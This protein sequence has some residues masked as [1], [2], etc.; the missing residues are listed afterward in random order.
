MKNR[1]PPIICCLPA[2][3][4]GGVHPVSRARQPLHAELALRGFTP[5]GCQ[6]GSSAAKAE[7]RGHI[8]KRSKTPDGRSNGYRRRVHGCV[9][10]PVG[11]EKQRLS[12]GLRLKADAS[13][14]LR[15]RGK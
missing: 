11:S 12:Q 2:L 7:A 3:F 1:I 4:C 13:G 9:D 6:S 5:A 10:R 8:A 14:A 15:A